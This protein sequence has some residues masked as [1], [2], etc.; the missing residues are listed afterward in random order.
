MSKPSFVQRAKIALNTFR[1]GF[2]R[3][4]MSRK[5]APFVWPAWRE[6]IPQWQTVSFET[7]VEQGFNLNSLVYSAIMYKVRSKMS[8]PLRAYG[9]EGILPPDHPLTQLVSR[10]NPYQSGVEFQALTEVYF[11]L[12]NAFVMLKRPKAGGMPEE[13]YSLRPDR[14]WIV[15]GEGGIKGYF[16]V[17]EGQGHQNGTPVLPE[18]MIHIKLPNPGDPL[19]GLGYGMPPTPIGQSVDVDNDVTRFMKLFFQNGAMLMGLL[20]YDIPLDDP[21][22]SAIKAR[23]MDVH[24]GME[25]WTE[26]GV[27]DQGGSYERIGATFDEMGFNA[28]DERNESRILGPLGVPPILIGSRIGLLRSTYSNYAQARQAYWEDTAVPEQ[29]LFET[30][31]QYYLQSEDGGYVKF[32][33]SGVP[34]LQK[35]VPNLVKSARTMWGMGVPANQA[36]KE[37]GLDVAP[38]SGGDIGYIPGNLLPVGVAPEQDGQSSEGAIE[39]QDDERKSRQWQHKVEPFIPLGADLPLPPVPGLVEITAADIDRAVAAWDQL[40][41]EAVGLMDAGGLIEIEKR[42]N[43]TAAT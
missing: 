32:D 27:L 8:A 14:V 37:V 26:V 2:P 38:I 28:I 43:G 21:T 41:P 12:G 35:D 13:M 42:T 29:T 36:F 3:R 5:D 19:E 4:Q 34:A 18:D 1:N 22:V 17:P 9:A 7:F 16:Y 20:K 25:N 24:G 10:P 11:N 15:P 33:R 30:N 40:M 39:A 31:Y 23:W 6:E